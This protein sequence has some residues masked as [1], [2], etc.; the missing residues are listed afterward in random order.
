MRTDWYKPVM[1]VAGAALRPETFN[2]A[3]RKGGPF[4]MPVDPE[5]YVRGIIPRL[6]SED[7]GY[8]R[9]RGLGLGEAY[10]QAMSAS[11]VVRGVPKGSWFGDREVVFTVSGPSALVSHLE[12]Q[13]IWLQFRIQVATL[14]KLAPERLPEVLGG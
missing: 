2:F 7:F 10:R 9:E 8:L 11:V 4:Y 12:A 6:S 3:I 5:E 14:G 13:I 1:A